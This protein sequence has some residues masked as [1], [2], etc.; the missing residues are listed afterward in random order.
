MPFGAYFPQRI[1]MQ[2]IL[3]EEY[4]RRLRLD[5]PEIIERREKL[6]GLQQRLFLA[7]RNRNKSEITNL[8]KQ[9]KILMKLGRDQY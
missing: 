2:S 1:A 7:K 9:I 3:R 6:A 5:D 4:P 8:E